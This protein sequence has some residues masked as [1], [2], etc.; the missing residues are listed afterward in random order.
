MKIKTSILIFAACVLS[1]SACGYK[2]KLK[3]PTQAKQERL[4]KEAKQQQKAEG[5][6]AAP[7]A[8]PQHV[9]ESIQ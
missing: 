8:Q 7:E 5:K 6:A 9:E 2:G 3:T 4:K 1:L